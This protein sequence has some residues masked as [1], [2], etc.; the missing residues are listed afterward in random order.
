MSAP[1]E[2]RSTPVA[3]MAA[4]VSSVTPPEASSH[5]LAAHELH[6]LGEHLG[7]HVVEQ[8]RVGLARGEHFFQL[9]EAVDL[10]LDLD[11][12]PDRGPRLLERRLHA[13][14]DRDVVVLDQH[15]VVEAEAV[16]EAAAAAHRVFLERAQPRRGLAGAADACLGVADLR[17]VSGGE[18][19]HAREAAEEIQRRALG[20]KDR[21]G[22]TFDL[23]EQRSRRDLVAVAMAG[24]EG[25]F[26]I[27]HQECAPRAF[28]AG[29]S[30]GLARDELGSGPRACGQ[31][32]RRGDVAGAAQVFVE[33]AAHRFVDDERGDGGAGSE[34]V[35]HVTL[36]L[37]WRAR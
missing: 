29:D 7:I 9:S 17:H 3:A 5:E 19:G 28:E 36:P 25:D 2:I 20:R 4:M 6:G 33:R 32:R 13:A 12:M 22:G 21:R 15:R 23:G 11:E 18:R 31:G 30:A 10:D 34:Q 1:D 37:R 8:H 35:G 26:L 16:I 24:A 27:E 14:G